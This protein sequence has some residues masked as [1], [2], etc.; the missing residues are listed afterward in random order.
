MRAGSSPSPARNL[1]LFVRSEEAQMEEWICQ[2]N[3]MRFRELLAKP[4]GDMQR[5]TLLKLL[6]REQVKL[7]QPAST[8]ASS[9]SMGRK[10]AG[11]ETPAIDA[12][13]HDV[14]PHEGRLPAP[15]LIELGR[16]CAPK[17]TK[18]RAWSLSLYAGASARQS[19]ALTREAISPYAANS[20]ERRIT[21]EPG[22]NRN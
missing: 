11:I 17:Q 20:N 9:P 14:R 18:K 19:M 3:I 5:A 12:N 6:A 16:I 15:R 13:R 2:Q 4:L 22:R 8:R 7:A 10:V 21:D 1:T